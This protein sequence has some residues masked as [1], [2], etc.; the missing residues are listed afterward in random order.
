MCSRSTCHVQHNMIPAADFDVPVVVTFPAGSTAVMV[1]IQISNDDICEN[2]EVFSLGLETTTVEENIDPASGTATIAIEDD[3]S[4]EIQN[5]ICI[6][7]FFPQQF[8]KLGLTQLATVF[9]KERL[10]HCSYQC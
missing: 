8:L 7:K 4:K 1:S 2:P 6:S 3:D 5:Y 9:L 10:K